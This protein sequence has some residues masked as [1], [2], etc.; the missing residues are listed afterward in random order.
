MS[1]FLA[2]LI[3][4]AGQRSPV[5]AR[6]K[7]AVFEPVTPRRDAGFPGRDP[8]EAVSPPEEPAWLGSTERRRVAATRPRATD[9]APLDQGEDHQ[10]TETAP[11]AALLRRA[12]RPVAWPGGVHAGPD[13]GSSAPSAVSPSRPTE[14][15]RAAAPPDATPAPRPP[16]RRAPSVAAHATSPSI[17]SDLPQPAR[18]MGR[19]V[20]AEPP[21]R[22]GRA[23]SDLETL[24]RVTGPRRETPLTAVPV[25]RPTVSPRIDRAVSLVAAA[26]PRLGAAVPG[27]TPAGPPPVLITIGRVEVR[28]LPGETRS[29]REARP[30]APKLSLEDYLRERAA[31]GR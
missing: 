15:P 3:R 30:A 6:R 10:G 13:L 16:L 12:P 19:P 29:P 4:R 7:R 22:S 31:G 21:P 8:S 26:Q 25:R 27:R 2:D 20:G 17:S 23:V 9:T 11:P 18:P 1:E 5:L 24:S 28:G 14:G